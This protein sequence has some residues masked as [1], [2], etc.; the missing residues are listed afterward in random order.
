MLTEHQIN[1]LAERAYQR[2]SVIN[3]EYLE[4]VGKT[5]GKIGELR[6]SDVH[7]LQQIY[8]YSGD[9]DKIIRNLEKASAKNAAEIYEI[10]D[11]V[12]KEN[13]DFAEPFYKAKGIEHVPYT[14]NK[15]LQ[16]Y[17]HSLAQQT[18][19]E[20]VNLSQH[21]AFAVFAKDGKSIAPLFEA[22]KNKLAT[23]LSDTYTNVVDYAV[24][25]VQMGLADYRMAMK[26]VIKAMAA[27]GIKTVDYA[28]G[29][30]RRLD[31]AVRQNILWGIKQCN[32]NVADFV[33]EEFGADGYEISY[34][35]NPRPSH[36]DMGGRQY[37]QGKAR[38]VDGVHYPSFEEEAEPLLN[39]YN[40]LHFKFP[41]LLGISNPTYSE[42][43]LLR[44]KKNDGQTFEFEGEEYTRYEG[45]QLQRQIETSIRHHKDIAN[46]AKAAGE[47]DLRREAQ[48]QIN[49]LAD[50]YDKLADESGLPTKMDR[51]Q[52]PGFRSV[53]A[54]RTTEGQAKY[55]ALVNKKVDEKQYK[56][57]INILGAENLPSSLD[58]FQKIKYM[59]I[60]QWDDIKY[61]VK[62]KE[63][64]GKIQC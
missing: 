27:S 24:S 64:I 8:D 33:G 36:E 23:S 19:N 51:M 22:N 4:S 16:D 57:Y 58:E 30:K 9:I 21:T 10:F 14:K 47:D 28:T 18:V 3:T 31:T 15:K 1:A 46:M 50:K 11:I 13:Y 45:T 52:V 34:H 17:V 20:Y 2:I 60:Q 26:E 62:Y 42:E 41:I 38:T 5:L 39:D 44:I 61:Y 55:K 6:P 48:Y 40:C 25:K 59:D 7:K 53:K 43:Q 35:S 12:A 49:L 56:K 37:A 54:K 29:Y 32:Q 63:V